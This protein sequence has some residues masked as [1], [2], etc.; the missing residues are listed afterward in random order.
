MKQKIFLALFTCIFSF[1]FFTSPAYAACPQ[2]YSCHNG[3]ESAG[4]C[5][6]NFVCIEE[7]D[8][9]LA[10]S[11]SCG[12]G[13]LQ[14]IKPPPFIGKLNQE[15]GSGGTGGIGILIFISTLLHFFA[16]ICGIWTL[17]NFLISGF[18]LITAQYDTKAQTDVKD[19][20]TMT[21]IGLVVIVAAYTFAGLF[22]LIFF[23]S[24][25]AIIN[26]KLQGALQ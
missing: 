16:V 2:G 14:G 11:E 4:Q 20:L 1:V 15:A 23:G 5:V 26:P 7:S 12:S 25:S 6:D 8:R 13:Q 17:F 3:C 24:A 21:V 19:R 22:G 9:I 10:G 18:T